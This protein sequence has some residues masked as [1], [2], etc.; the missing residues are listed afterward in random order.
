MSGRGRRSGPGVSPARNGSK[1]IRPKR[2]FT[3]YLR[4]SFTCLYCGTSTR[5]LT[6]DHV[7]GHSNCSSNLAT[8]C[9]SCNSAKR[10][11]SQRKWYTLLRKRE[12]LSIQDT[13]RIQSRLYRQL[14]KP[15]GKPQC[16]CLKKVSVSSLKSVES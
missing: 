10:N 11:V 16:Q 4:D 3:I 14:K 6:L 2:R 9:L 13:K 7:Y 8:C 15:L 1:W 5:S 12:G